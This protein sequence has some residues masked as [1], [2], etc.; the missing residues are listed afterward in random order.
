MK[1][2]RCRLET[3]DYKPAVLSLSRMAAS[4][5]ATCVAISASMV[6]RQASGLWRVVDDSE[7]CTV[8]FDDA[9]DS[10]LV[11]TEERCEGV[12]RRGEPL[13]DQGDGGAVFQGEDRFAAGAGRHVSG[14]AAALVKC[15]LA[16]GVPGHVQLIDQRFPRRVMEPGQAG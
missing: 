16:L 14:V 9:A 4:A 6:R 15:C 7:R 1:G 5:F 12:F 8:L 2:A 10:L 3:I 13:I 11:H